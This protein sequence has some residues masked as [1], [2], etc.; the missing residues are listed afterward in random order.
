MPEIPER[1]W[2]TIRDLK[3]AVLDRACQRLLD[4]LTAQLQTLPTDSTHHERY[5]AVYRWIQAQDDLMAKGFDD[6]RRRNAY[7][8]LAFWVYQ[9]WLTWPEF[10]GLRQETQEK[11]L[12]LAGLERYTPPDV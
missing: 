11:V 10:N 1:E 7:D 4:E 3:P 6:L 9:G 12:S 8:L 5:L 2:R